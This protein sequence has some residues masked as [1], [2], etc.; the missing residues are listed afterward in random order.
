MVGKTE[1][2]VTGL[3]RA[4]AIYQDRTRRI[5]ELKAGGR[6]VFGYLDA[7]PVLEMLTA[8]DIIPYAIL[9]DLDEPITRADTCLPTVVCPF[10]RS[11]MDLGLKGRYDFL[12][13]IAMAHSC[14]VAEKVAHIWRIYLKPGYAHFIDTPHT[15][16]ASAIRQHRELLQEFK[17]TL[18]SFAGKQITP[19]RLKQAIALHNRQRDLVRQ[20]YDLRK[21]DPPLI[22]G[23]EMLQVEIAVMS[24]PVE[25]GNEL[26]TEVINNVRERRDVPPLKP[27]RLLLWGSMIDDTALLDVIESAGAN[28]VIDDT[29]VGTRAFFSKVELT[30]DPLDDLARRYLVGIQ[31]PRTFR[32]NPIS[33]GRKDYMADLESRFGYLKEYIQEWN[34]NGVILQAL[35]YCDIHAYEVPSLRDY[36]NR[37][38]L[39]STYLEHDYS[40]AAMEQ[41]RTRVQAFI[42]VIG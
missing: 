36:L 11:I 12:D 18:E 17:N 25:E 8:L 15:T 39:P 34:V 23:A 33:D 30:D 22:S 9:G 19:E 14:E 2:T 27:V 29:F 20:L 26:L 10:L 1:Q 41:L 37:I 3:A 32:E 13:G 24:L 28:V 5:N 40:K 38:G 4:R 35:R 16:H 42:E 31:N 6:K 7:Y 21:P